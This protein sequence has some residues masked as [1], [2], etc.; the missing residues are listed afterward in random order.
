MR[1]LLFFSLVYI[2]A[3][4][5]YADEP[6]VTV[7]SYAQMTALVPPGDATLV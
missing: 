2:L 4:S 5:A 3:L 6:T 7:T 1:K